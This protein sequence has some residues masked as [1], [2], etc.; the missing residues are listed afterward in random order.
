MKKKVYL[1]MILGLVITILLFLQSCRSEG[2]PVQEAVKTPVRLAKVEF[3]EMAKT[4]R[5]YGR[6]ATKEEIKLSFKINGIIRKIFVDEGRAVKKGQILA[7]L[8]LSEI[9]SQVKQAR[10]AF[11]KAKRDMERVENLYR[12]KAATLEQYQN[13]QTAYKVAQSQLQAAEFNLRYSEI[14]APSKGRILKRLMGEN[15]LVGAGMPVFF[16][17]STEKDWIVRV[18]ISDSDLVRVKL[19]DPAKVSFDAYPDVDFQA[20]VSEIV[21]LADP[22]TGTYELELKVRS[23]DKRLA[24]GFVAKVEIF[25]FSKKDYFIIPVEALVEADGNRAYVYALDSDL[26]KAR[27]LSVK[28][29]FLFDDK[30]AIESGLE[31]LAFVISEGAPYLSDGA[32]VKVI[33]DQKT[34]Q[35]EEVKDEDL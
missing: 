10:S 7:R 29:G 30:V 23:G 19:G 3:A 28:I 17:A 20:L 6:L 27:R 25:P 22:L 24:S 5:T 8:D 35:E 21:E 34:H 13:V 15:E 31:K 12:E 11:E 4:I 32:E 9:A 2:E 1:L 26:A 18:G 33:E 14:R 16:F